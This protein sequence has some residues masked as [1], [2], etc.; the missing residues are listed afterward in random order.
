VSRLLTLTVAIAAVLSGL[1]TGYAQQKQKKQ[2]TGNPPYVTVPP[3]PQPGVQQPQNVCPCYRS[4]GV[5][6]GYSTAACC[7]RR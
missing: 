6:A 7:F 1:G 4:N 5:Y 2:P 3:P